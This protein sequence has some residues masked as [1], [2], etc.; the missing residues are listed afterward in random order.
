MTLAQATEVGMGAGR[1]EAYRRQSC[2]AAKLG[3]FAPGPWYKS[4]LLKCPP[5]PL[6]E[7]V[8][9]I[10]PSLTRVSLKQAVHKIHPF[11]K[12]DTYSSPGP[13]GLQKRSGHPFRGDMIGYIGLQV[14]CDWMHIYVY[15]RGRTGQG[16]A[17]HSRAWGSVAAQSGASG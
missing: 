15:E 5:G 6:C 3:E 16:K 17:T 14:V 9:K 7:S 12:I 8:P 1:W 10:T 4:H 2:M 11:S 13:I